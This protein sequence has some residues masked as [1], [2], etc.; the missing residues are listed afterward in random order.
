MSE[1]AEFTDFYS[2]NS[3]RVYRAVVA[4][5]GRLESAEDATAEAFQRAWARWRTVRD[6]PAPVAWVTLTAVNIVRDDARRTSR[7]LRLAPKLVSETEVPE[8]TTLDPHLVS[9]IARLP[10]RQREVL[11]L[12][13]LLDLSAEQT[14][15]ELDISAGTVGTHLSRALAALRAELATQ[16]SEQA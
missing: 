1:L 4:A 10:E 5:A 3:S 7:A 16:L 13:V 15:A 2:A 14:A 8:P 9:C 12:R 11:A 6:H